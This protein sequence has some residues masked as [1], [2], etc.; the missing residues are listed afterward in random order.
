[1]QAT[2]LLVY[3][4]TKA[5]KRRQKHNVLGGGNKRQ[6]K[7]KE[8]WKRCRS[9]IRGHVALS[10]S[11]LVVDL[12][13]VIIGESGLLRGRWSLKQQNKQNH[14]VLAP[15]NKRKGAAGD[16]RLMTAFSL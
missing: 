11:P 13:F 9:H 8:W 1:M 7:P 5:D 16:Q 3:L 12:V 10:S 4:K 15:W 6:T 2:G 14:G